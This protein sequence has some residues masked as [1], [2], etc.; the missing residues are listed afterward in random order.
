MLKHSSGYTLKK[1]GNSWYLL[2]FG[3]QVADQH[4]AVVLNETGAFLWNTL[5][6]TSDLEELTHHLARYYEVPESTCPELR[7]DVQTFFRQLLSFGILEEN[8]APKRR[9]DTLNLEI[10]GLLLR[11]NGP[12]S[13]FPKEFSAFACDPKTA[14]KIT[15]EIHLICQSPTKQ[16]GT[17]LLRNRE[18][19]ILEHA[20]GYVM[21]FPTL[22][23][24]FEAHMTKDGHLV[25]IYCSSAVTESNLENLFHAIRPFFLFI[26]QKNGKFAVHSASL[27]YKEKA[28]LFSGHSGM[29][30]STHTNLWKELF[31]TPLL[32]GDLNLIGEENGQFFVYG[33]PWCGTSGICTTE[34]QRLG[35]IVLLGRDAKDNRFEIMTPAERVLRV[36]QRMISPS[37]TDELVSRSLAFAETLTDEIPVFHFLCMKNPSAA[38]KMRQ[39]IDL[40]EAVKQ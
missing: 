26:A 12:A 35:G 20:D 17:V 22:K 10:A 11:L 9:D 5:E 19:S 28:W 3:Q 32:N 29:G 6:H 39:R 24:I 36:M 37:W 1:V 7:E 8:L 25:Q 34:K 30:K 15:Q 14:Q 38:H 2:P 27:L 40:W 4:K 33:I 13:L 31:G 16:N 18:L 21:L 23:N